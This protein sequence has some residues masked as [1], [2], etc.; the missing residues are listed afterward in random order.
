MFADRPR[1]EIGS[2]RVLLIGAFILLIPIALIT[3]TIRVAIS[4]TALYDYAVQNYGASAASGITEH[5]LL[6]ANKD[7]RE[8][9]VDPD[10]GPL[11][12][13]VVNSAGETESLFN[14]RE[15]AHMADVRSLVQFMF[16]VQLIAVAS[17]LA[18]AVAMVALFPVRALA[19]AS[20]Y[21]AL[22]TLAVL[23]VAGINAT[24]G[25]DAFWSQFHGIAFT[26]NLWELDPDTDHL[27][28]M[29][30]EAFWQDAVM[31]LGG[32]IAI[33]ALL[34]GIVSG[35]YLLLSRRRETLAPPPDPR[36]LPDREREQRHPRLSPPNPRH[37]VR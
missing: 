8:Y 5:Q 1:Q 34:L 24:V 21:G 29:F 20:L 7:I 14:A 32:L 31:T 17:V 9:L 15:T 25:F 11:A 2:V 23:G 22:L 33:Q 13:Q 28:Q 36:P 35:L 37:Y 16:T 10:A 27:I 19:A 12:P 4:E 18:L 26:N 3:T 30:P 6:R